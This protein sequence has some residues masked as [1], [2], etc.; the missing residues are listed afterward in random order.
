MA[1]SLTQNGKIYDHLEP[2]WRDVT[3]GSEEIIISKRFKI[4]TLSVRITRRPVALEDGVPEQ[5]WQAV[6]AD[7]YRPG[8]SREWHRE[9]RWGIASLFFHYRFEEEDLAPLLR[10][11]VDHCLAE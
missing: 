11:A 9:T 3:D 1:R 8:G 5:P 6:P 4:T 10:P 7:D 2:E